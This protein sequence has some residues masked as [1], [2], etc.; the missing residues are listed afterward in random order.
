MKSIL[1]WLG[2]I[3]AG[4]IGI[5]ALIAVVGYG[6][7]E[8]RINKSYDIAVEPITIPT[9][10]AS[11]EEGERLTTIRGCNDCHSADF[12]GKLFLDDAMLGTFSTANLTSGAGSATAG[13]TVED[14]D[15]AIRHGVGMDGKGVLIM[16]SNEF[17]ALS[18]E[19]LGQIVAYL[20]TVSPVDREQT[21][22]KLGP[23]GRALFLMG[24]LPLL[25]AE[26]IDHSVDP[27]QAVEPT[28][29]VEYGA[30][31]VTTCIGCHQPN[32][33][34][35]PIPGSAPGDPPSANLT[36]AGNL[37]NW[38]LEDFTFVLRN[39]VTPEGKALDP[40][41]MPWTMTQHMTDIEIEALWIYLQTLPPVV[42]NG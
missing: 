21:E 23:L 24:Q 35:G 39:G 6:V 16:P 5:V 19:Q 9:D 14:W 28:A 27:P 29:S 41:Q 1:K 11:L 42:L 40:L 22:S 33:A 38:T 30:Y 15:R 10:A 7:S 4:L 8:R 32:L 26:V 34:G 12:G 20:Q 17:A 3:L 13:F 37:A 2:I 31:M 25:P 18:D 36:P